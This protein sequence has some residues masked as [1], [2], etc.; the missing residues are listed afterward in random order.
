MRFSPEFIQRVEDATDIVSLISEKGIALKRAGTNYKACCPFHSEKTP[1]FSVNPHRGFFHCFGCGVGGNALKFLMLFER[2]SFPEAIL[3][4]SNHAGISP[5]YTGSSAEH[6]GTNRTLE[7]LKQAA[8]YYQNNLQGSTNSEKNVEQTSQVRHYLRERYIQD[9]Q[10]RSFQLG[11]ALPGWQNLI[12]A[13]QAQKFQETEMRQG[14]LVKSS[15][16]SNRP[17]D[18]FRNRLIFPIRDVRG[19]CIG[20]GARALSSEDAPKYLNSP[21][22][23]Y[24]KKNQVLYGLY[25]GFQEIRKLRQ[26]ILVEGYLDVIRMHEYGYLQTVATCGTAL[27]P[28]HIRIMTQY[29]DSVILVFDGD[30]AGQNAALKSSILFLSS[31]LE[32]FILRLP[33]NEDPDSFLLNQGESAFKELLKDK[34][35]TLKY[36]VTQTLNNAPP[37]AQGRTQ[38]LEKLL[39]LVQQ[40]PKVE[41]RQM[42]LSELST[43][44]KI[45]TEEVF[46]ASKHLRFTKNTASRENLPALT[47]EGDSE[48]LRVLQVL[49]T[50][51][52]L[53]DFAREHLKVEEFS[54]PQ[55]RSVYACFLKHSKTLPHFT[56]DAFSQDSPEVYQ[57]ILMLYAE[58]F[59]Q[60]N[61]ELQIK[62][63]IRRIKTRH[64]DRISQEVPDS[65][66]M[67]ERMRLAIQ[68]RQKK[69]EL[70]RFSE[71]R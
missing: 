69:E 28:E 42:T 23:A 50:Q 65:I 66:S 46:R 11:F 5:E 48:E 22:T 3:D 61:L 41:L 56:P 35:P 68:L 54:S 71:H 29:A 47:H 34:I 21:E 43:L 37:T 58:G 63:S 33:E 38:V 62:L 15:E 27:T 7:C 1:S 70:K 64:L 59:V 17:Y 36:L 19:R 67:K 44:L 20:F 39:P 32:S 24:Y 8:L 55:Y 4:L 16:K 13:L 40:I 25:E 18:C 9:E 53:I 26:M 14:G 45:P 51:W 60:K 57:L 31:S 52:D 10:E 12:S 30:K 6:Q 2:I 49:M